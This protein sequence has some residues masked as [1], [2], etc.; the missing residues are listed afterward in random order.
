MI[1]FIDYDFFQT[2][3]LSYPNLEM[4]K[5]SSFLTFDSGAREFCRLL[6]P[7]EPDLE[8][9]EEIHFFAENEN[10]VIPNLVRAH[11][12]AHYHGLYFTDG[13]YKPFE[14]ELIEYT[15]PRPYIYVEY[16]KKRLAENLNNYRE[17][18]A[19][20]KFLNSTYYRAYVNG[21]ILPIP[22]IKR[23]ERLYLYD[24]NFFFDGW[25]AVIDEI[26]ARNPSMIV[27]VHPIHCKTMGQYLRVREYEK[28]ARGN[29]VWWDLPVPLT[30][31]NYLFKHYYAE[32]KN[33]I[34]IPAQ[35]YL[36]IGGNSLVMDSYC[37]RELTYK[38]NLLYS[39]WARSIPLKLRYVRPTTGHR[40]PME[41]LF[42]ELEE[43]G[44]IS[45]PYRR[46]TAFIDFVAKKNKA[47][48]SAM[49]RCGED[50]QVLFNQSYNSISYYKFWR[51][52]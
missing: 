40:N 46:D 34:T 23:K 28:L 32:L 2:S 43:W 18:H 39:F 19:L 47:V 38:L 27:C 30:D 37:V 35:V 3:K 5:L 15:I 45:T 29:E 52:T 16:L 8:A 9:Y 4:M 6:S 12:N 26:T 33:D 21:K 22:A 36:P 50:T 10:C 25:E 17:I 49:A 20:K 13:V 31:I 7:D 42:E 48:R 1:G 51:L 41:E 11:P 14:R 44:S 24:R